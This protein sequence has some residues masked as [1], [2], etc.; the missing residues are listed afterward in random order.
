MKPIGKLLRQPVVIKPQKREIGDPERNYLIGWF[1]DVLN[2]ANRRDGVKEVTA[3]RVVGDLRG[4]E[5]HDLGQDMYYLKKKMEEALESGFPVGA[6]F[7][8]TIKKIREAKRAT[9]Q[10]L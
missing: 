6:V 2:E 4:I 3:K 5:V 9:L 8:P 10:K 1:R 7:Y